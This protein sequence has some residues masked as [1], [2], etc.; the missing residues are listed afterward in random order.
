MCEAT[1]KMTWAISPMIVA[2]IWNT[3][4]RPVNVHSSLSAKLFVIM[5]FEV[6]SANALV[7]RTNPSAVAFMNTRRNAVPIWPSTLTMAQ[8]MFA[9]PWTSAERPPRSFHIWRKPFRASALDLITEPS[10]SLIEVN[11]SVASSKSPKRI[12][13]V[14]AH[15]DPIASFVVSISWLK[16]RTL[17]AASKAFWANCFILWACSSE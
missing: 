7:I 4:N 15:P 10:Q 5:S 8:K 2:K 3:E 17:V 12:S 6:K 11:R 1:V 14:S 13:N 16:V 9:K